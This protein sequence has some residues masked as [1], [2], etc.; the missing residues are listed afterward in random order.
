[1]FVC[2]RG[3]VTAPGSNTRPALDAAAGYANLLSS[4][5]AAAGDE[6]A[7]LLFF[8]GMVASSSL[9]PAAGRGLYTVSRIS[10]KEPVAGLL[11]AREYST[12]CCSYCID[13]AP[14]WLSR[15]G[16]ALQQMLC[17]AQC[18]A[19]AATNRVMRCCNM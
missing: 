13:H 1:V 3:A 14:C 11:N 8:N 16:G 2:P 19:S 5:A 9:G 6:E 18:K 10:A 7:G 4:R 12:H 15:R 17:I